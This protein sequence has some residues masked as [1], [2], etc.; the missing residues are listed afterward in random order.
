[1]VEDVFSAFSVANTPVGTFQT[2]GNSPILLPLGLM[3][4]TLFKPILEGLG[5]LLLGSGL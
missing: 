2:V 1:M 3:P 5:L 4:L